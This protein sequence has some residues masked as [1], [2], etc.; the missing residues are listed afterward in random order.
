[1][2]ESVMKLTVDERWARERDQLDCTLGPINATRTRHHG[3]PLP[4][5]S[6]IDRTKR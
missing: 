3:R 2:H 4:S 6:T 5:S 1:M